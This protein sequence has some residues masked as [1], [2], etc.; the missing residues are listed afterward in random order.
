MQ[1]PEVTMMYLNKFTLWE[2][3]LIDTE[4]LGVNFQIAQNDILSFI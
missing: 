3:L 4:N 2:D 1:A